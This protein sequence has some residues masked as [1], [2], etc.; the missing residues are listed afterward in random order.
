M[1]LQI[2]NHLI[3]LIISDRAQDLDWDSFSSA[4][5]DLLVQLAQAEGVASLLY[6]K[7]SQSERINL[8]PET[9]QKSLRAVYFS[10]RMKNDAI[11]K[12]LEILTEIFNQAGIPVVALKGI[13]FLLTIYPDIGLRPMVDMDLLMP[14]SK[15]TEAV[16]IAKSLGYVE[17]IPEASPGLEDLL[18]HALCL[19]KTV[20]PF[21]TLEIHHGLV[22][23]R[24]FTFAVPVDWFWS[25]TEAMD[26][27]AP[28]LRINNLL[29]LSPIAQ[30]LYASAHAM[31][32]HGG[33]NTSLRWLYDLDRLIR[34][35]AGR[36]D[37]D[38]LLSQA[39]I[40]EWGSAVF[41]ALSQT[42][43]YF[44][45]PVPRKIL[46]DLSKH[47]DRN[48][49]LVATLQD[50]PASHTLEEYQKLKSLN[51]S[52][53]F[54]LTLAL[55]APSPAY[56]RWR[57]NLKTSGALPAWYL[58]RWWVIFKDALKTVWMLIHKAVMQASN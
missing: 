46:D 1:S 2:D 13:C 31:L 8:L 33:S 38:L 40:F 25:Q 11:I 19:I 30:V 12:E 49:K 57:Y 53:R 50:Q 14:V 27:L 9:L 3:S 55:V 20:S 35:Y 56:M 6:W 39:R 4:D 7:L 37:W 10:V 24:S 48:T 45:T 51:W 54:K 43:A 34:L 28:K 16:Q 29:M 15:L 32:Q 58:Y 5:W 52:G 47:S 17:A 22:A 42:V 26:G 18:N 23:D 44:D 41:A 21:T 36:M